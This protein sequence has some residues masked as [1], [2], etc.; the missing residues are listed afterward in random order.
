MTYNCNFFELQGWIYEKTVKIG[1]K[2]KCTTLKIFMSGFTPS[3]SLYYPN[4]L[5]TFYPRC[6]SYVSNSTINCICGIYIIKD[7]IDQQFCKL[8]VNN[9]HVIISHYSALWSQNLSTLNISKLISFG[10][11]SFHALCYQTKLCL[12]K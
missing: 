6:L 8:Y 3:N 10:L 11:K 7:N 4:I 2:T 12:T 1:A 5:C 9:W